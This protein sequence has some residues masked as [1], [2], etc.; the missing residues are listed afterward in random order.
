M[1]KQILL[2][3]K[4]ISY[5]LNG[6]GPAVVLLHGFLESLCIWKDMAS[7]LKAHFTVVSVDLPGFGKSDVLASNHSMSLMADTVNHILE[8][9]NITQCVMAGHSM[10]GYVSLA[11]AEKYPAK[12]QGLVLFHSQAAADDAETKKNRDRTIRLVEND[13]KSFI[14]SFIPLLFAEENVDNYGHEIEQLEILS[15]LAPV[16]GICAA[17]AGMRDR[18]DQLSLLKNIDVPVFFIIGKQDAKIPM[19][20]VLPQ[21]EIPKNCEALI[22]DGVG[23]MGFIE[24]REM[25]SRALTHFVERMN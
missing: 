17:L 11:F 4:T 12:L 14:H 6:S 13:R 1:E 9:E 18:N 20:T 8:E 24:A 25:T 10:G 19:E 3:D 2:Q 5:T 22:L 23:H 16:E 7:T 15:E 21:L